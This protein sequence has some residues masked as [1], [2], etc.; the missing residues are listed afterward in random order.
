MLQKQTELANLCTWLFFVFFILFFHVN[1]TKRNYNYK[2]DTLFW[3]TMAQMASLM[4]SMSSSVGERSVTKFTFEG[5]FSRMYIIMV[6]EFSFVTEAFTADVAFEFTIV[7]GSMFRRQ[8]VRHSAFTNHNTAHV[9]WNFIMEPF[10][11]SF[12]GILIFWMMVAVWTWQFIVPV[13]LLHVPVQISNV[14]PTLFAYFV[15]LG[16]LL[17]LFLILGFS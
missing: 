17:L 13:N 10:N 4:H 16:F 2:S 5:L 8:M 3:T 12:Q 7:Y 11:M 15:R 9:T 14:F 6:A 1:N